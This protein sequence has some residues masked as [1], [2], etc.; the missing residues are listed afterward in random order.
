M[1]RQCPK[2]TTVPSSRR[3]KPPGVTNYAMHVDFDKT[4]RLRQLAESTETFEGVTVGSMS[5]SIDANKQDE[6][7][8]I[9]NLDL[10]DPTARRGEQKLAASGPYPGDDLTNDETFSG[11]RFH[12]YQTSPTHHCIL[13]KARRT[14]NDVLVP[15]DLL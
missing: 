3:D 8:N 6:T 11:Q 7:W 13:D 10:G 12:I 4:E 1:S 5:L 9:T 14:E 2:R 15:S